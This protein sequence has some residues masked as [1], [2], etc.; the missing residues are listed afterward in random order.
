MSEILGGNLV[1]HKFPED[2]DIK[3]A[4]KAYSHTVVGRQCSKMLD[5][6]E[7]G[8]LCKNSVNVYIQLIRV[9]TVCDA[10][11]LDGNMCLSCCYCEYSDGI[12]GSSESK[13]STIVLERIVG[14][15]RC[16][17]LLELLRNLDNYEYWKE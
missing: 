3:M 11:D 17:L 14:K 6:I 16:E 2:Y 8:S 9:L 5:A 10:I 13:K 15:E 1:Y 12:Y 7:D 4:N